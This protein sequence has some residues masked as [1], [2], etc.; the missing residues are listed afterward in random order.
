MMAVSP[1]RVDQ[2]ERQD[3][4]QAATARRYLDA[5]DRAWLEPAAP[6]TA[7][8]IEA[9]NQ[10]RDLERQRARDRY[11]ERHDVRDQE[12]AHRE[13]W[14]AFLRAFRASAPAAFIEHCIEPAD[15]VQ[16]DSVG[17]ELADLYERLAR[18]HRARANVAELVHELEARGLMMR[19]GSVEVLV[20]VRDRPARGHRPGPPRMGTALRPSYEVWCKLSAFGR[21]LAQASS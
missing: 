21:R 19:A 9:M 5:V 7:D 2:L 13:R 16:P 6:V 4:V 11:Q 20:Q 18:E 12:H 8:Q 3:H 15:Q 17:E 14:P 10:R 1:S